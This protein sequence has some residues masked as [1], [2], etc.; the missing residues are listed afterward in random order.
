M[1]TATASRAELLLEE[2]DPATGRL[3]DEAIERICLQLEEVRSRSHAVRNLNMVSN[4]RLAF[5]T[6]GANVVGVGMNK[7]V[8][9]RLAG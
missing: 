2:L 4:L 8:Y 7:A 3:A 1:R 5:E 9:I 6:I